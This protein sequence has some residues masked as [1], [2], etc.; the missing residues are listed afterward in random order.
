MTN[1]DEQIFCLYDIRYLSEPDRATL[2]F[3][4]HKLSDVKKE[5]YGHL[6]DSVIVV[7]FIKDGITQ[8]E[9]VLS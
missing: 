1:Y 3:A 4:S 7:A 2:L 9:T 8:Y 6:H 5:K